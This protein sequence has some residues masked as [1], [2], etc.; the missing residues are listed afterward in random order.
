ML[1]LNQLVMIIDKLIECGLDLMD[2]VSEDVSVRDRSFTALHAN[3]VT[4]ITIGLIAHFN[5][6]IELLLTLLHLVNRQWA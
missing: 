3:Y 2:V 1:F 4:L 6:R 5:R